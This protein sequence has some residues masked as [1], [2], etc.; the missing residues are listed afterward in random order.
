MCSGDSAISSDL[1]RKEKKAFHIF[2]L[3][4]HNDLVVFL[5]VGFHSYG[6][7]LCSKKAYWSNEIS[8][9]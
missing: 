7:M 9:Q 6:S 3:T 1:C 5:G 2:S 4:V 8:L